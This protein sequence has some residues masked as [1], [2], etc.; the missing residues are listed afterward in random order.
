VKCVGSG[1]TYYKAGLSIRRLELCG[2]CEVFFQSVG[3]IISK[4]RVENNNSV[5]RKTLCQIIIETSGAY[6]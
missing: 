5:N 3:D 1:K 2:I 4:Q 6:I